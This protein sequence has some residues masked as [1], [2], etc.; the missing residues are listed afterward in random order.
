MDGVDEAFGSWVAAVL[1]TLLACA[2]LAVVVPSAVT[3]WA[4]RT[5]RTRCGSSSRSRWSE[6]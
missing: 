4:A 1:I 5:N 3:V 6:S 2:I